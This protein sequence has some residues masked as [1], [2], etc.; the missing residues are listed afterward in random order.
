M[1]TQRYVNSDDEDTSCTGVKMEFTKL[2]EKLR[3]T[4]KK[5]RNRER[6]GGEGREDKADEYT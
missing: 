5:K 2:E 6:K 1:K 3:M 4:E